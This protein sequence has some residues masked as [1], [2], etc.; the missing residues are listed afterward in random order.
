MQSLVCVATVVSVL[1]GPEWWLVAGPHRHAMAQKAIVAL[2]A[3][4]SFT[5]AVVAFAIVTATAFVVCATLD[6]VVNSRSPWT[7]CLR[8]HHAW[9]LS[10]WL[11]TQQFSC[12]VRVTRISEGRE[13]GGTGGREERDGLG[14]SAWVGFSV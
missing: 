11:G 5:A 7:S 12:W 3:A 4:C 13:A 1:W 9:G 6:S 14:P 10:S 8:F 2:G